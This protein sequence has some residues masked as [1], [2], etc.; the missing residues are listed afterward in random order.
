MGSKLQDW[1]AQHRICVACGQAD[2]TPHRKFCWK[3]LDDK[4]ER[5]CKYRANMTEE[6]KQAARKKLVKE[7]K[8]SMLSE[9]LPENAH[10]A[11]KNRQNPEKLI[12]RCA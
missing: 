2:A 6:Q 11:E 1:Y 4:R 7:V 12:V 3:C 5:T 8:S 9:K 10:A